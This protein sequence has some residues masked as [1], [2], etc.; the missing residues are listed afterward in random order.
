MRIRNYI[1]A[2]LFALTLSAGATIIG[3]RFLHNAAP[4]APILLET[5]RSPAIA[6]DPIEGSKDPASHAETDLSNYNTKEVISSEARLEALLRRQIA[7]FQPSRTIRI[8]PH[9]LPNMKLQKIF[10]NAVSGKDS[11]FMVVR[12][13]YV[14]TK[15]IGYATL[16]SDM[17]YHT[18]KEQDR[19]VDLFAAEW[20]K[21]NLRMS[22]S[23]EEKVKAIHDHIIN[24]SDYHLGDENDRF[25]GLSVHSPYTLS[26]EK[27]GVCQAY[28]ILFYKIATAA[29]IPCKLVPGDFESSFIYQDD[30]TQHLWNMVQIDGKWYHI[31][32]TGDD[33][34][35]KNAPNARMLSYEYYLKSDATMARSHSWNL[36]TYPEAL[37]DYEVFYSDVI[38][39]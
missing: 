14:F 6:K 38:S 27:V 35:I 16:R 10:E 17:D 3:L 28:A 30:D 11:G 37:E 26:K 31:D 8:D 7:E 36:D 29:D 19:S 13:S 4:S 33:P 20:A 34:I 1:F 23:Q 2:G 21:N 5:E 24:S 9:K 12:W 15:H 25:N 39:D 18:T 22:M 32:V